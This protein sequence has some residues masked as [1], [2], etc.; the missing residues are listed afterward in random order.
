MKKAFITSFKKNR[1]DIV[2]EWSSLV[3]KSTR[4]YKDLSLKETKQSV[5]RHLDAIIEVLDNENFDALNDFLNDLARIRLRKG[6]NVKRDTVGISPW[7]DSH[8]TPS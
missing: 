1:P 3:R 5:G 8:S 4:H 2:N 7:A 6:F